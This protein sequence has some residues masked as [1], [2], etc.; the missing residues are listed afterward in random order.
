GTDFDN[1]LI[2]GTKLFL[3]SSFIAKQNFEEVIA[4]KPDYLFVTGDTTLNGEIQ[5]HI[6]MANMLRD[7]QNKVRAA[8]KPN[9]QVFVSIGN[10]DIYNLDA[11]HY[12]DGGT[13]KE[14]THL[15]SRYDITKVY[16]SLGFPDL[17]NQEIEDYYATLTDIYFDRL[18]YEGNYVNSTT[19]ADVY[20][21]YQYID[22]NVT[23]DYDNGDITYIAYLP[24]D[25]VLITMDEEISD[26]YINHHV[27]GYFYESIRD[28]LLQKQEVGAFDGQTLLG[29]LHHNVVPHFPMEESLLKDFTIYG[30]REVADFFADLG[31]RYAF[32]GHMHS[33]DIAKHESLNNNII[34][35][36]ETGSA[37][38]YKG[39]TRY[40]MLERGTVGGN[41]AENYKSKIDLV[42]PVDI[43]VL[44]AENYIN[45]HYIEYC[46]LQDY[47]THTDNRYIINNPSEYAVTKLFRNVVNNVKYTYLD[48]EFI[49]NAGSM[50]GGLF[51]SDDMI[52]SLALDV[53]E[54]LINN[55]I[56]HIED[57]VLADYTYAGDN[58]KYLGEGRGKKLCAYLEEMVD[59]ALEY[60]MNARGDTLFDIG[61]GGY[62]AH[63]GGIDTSLADADPAVLEALQNLKNG[64]AVKAMLDTLLDEQTG[65]LRIV[66]GLFLPI[67]LTNELSSGEASIVN[68]LLGALW[69]EGETVD[70]SAVLLDEL[71]P[72]VLEL[73]EALTGSS[74]DLGGKT[75][76]QF[77]DYYLEGYITESLY[78]GLGEIAHNILHEFYIDETS[79][80]E[81]S[82]DSYITYSFDQSLP[83]TYVSDRTPEAPSIE[84][85]KLPSM[86]T[87]TFGN[88]PS[89]TKNFVWF[90]DRRISGTEIQYCEGDFD[91][92]EAVQQS[93]SFASY[94]TTT[95]SIDLGVFATLMHVAVGRHEV[96]VTG[97]A[98]ATTYSYR[99]GSAE[100][101]YWSDI[102]TFKTAPANDTTPFELLLIS[103]IQGSAL[104]TYELSN[105]ILGKVN[106]VFPNGY[107]FVLNCG[108]V[109]DNSK[110][111]VQWR[112]LL[113]TMQS[114]WGNTTQVVASGNHDE[115]TYEPVEEGEI[116]Y[117]LTDPDAIVTPYS[118]LLLH[119]NFDYPAQDD[120]TG[121]YY[122]FDY[123]GV[124]FTVLNTSNLDA[125]NRLSEEQVEWLQNDLENTDKAHKVVLMHKSIYSSGSHSTDADVV[126]MRAQLT[127][128]FNQYGVR[129]VLAGHDH[130]YTE[131]YY[132]GADGKQIKT[133]AQGK[134]KIGAEGTLYITLGTFG[135]K[136][137]NYVENPEVPVEFGKDL[138]NPTLANP[139]FGKL[140]FDGQDLYY[141]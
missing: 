47:I 121:A 61:V 133:D 24:D 79:A 140:V 94:A 88:E 28:Y 4:E 35:D 43:T 92:D 75:L 29:I 30:W 63:Q 116:A 17:S 137:Y 19:A 60:P 72:K 22:N 95:A 26:P 23:P 112:Y 136:Y 105:E 128:I 70:G 18:P 32:T 50:L 113:D 64:T 11:V 123:S 39:G 13:K 46:G 104:S 59:K 90:T 84:N 9:F 57:V 89:T 108:D 141:Y 78:T 45:E 127:P 54:P 135:D 67:D 139:T 110:N 117:S 16:S 73:M 27:G 14:C 15:T 74:I 103:D 8:G 134:S 53:A 106:S 71:V 114:H 119:Y 42:D 21:E 126:A 125:D 5:A 2:G 48:P 87:V 51:S 55:L 100:K 130:T 52:I 49:A 96:A 40:V 107:D 36:T 58:P 83:C 132:L 25:Y 76:E 41:Y 66:R 12:R 65:L 44:F 86:L 62:L 124:H 69:P 98:P 38:G 33:N 37:T 129:L 81:N 138:H 7:L 1:S 118:Y 82:F 122:S 109:V 68:F 102:Y 20:I 77:L 10:H 3:E 120:L 115:Y 6:E 101:G 97:L 56:V 85:G 93:G 131:S 91:E 99:V 31:M 111:L 80:L 34:I